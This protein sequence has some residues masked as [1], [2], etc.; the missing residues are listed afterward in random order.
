MLIKCPVGKHGNFC[1]KMGHLILEP[2]RKKNNTIYSQHRDKKFKLYPSSRKRGSYYRVHHYVSDE[3]GKRKSKWCYLGNFD[4]ALE[5][6][7]KIEKSL[8]KYASSKK[9]SGP[10]YDVNPFFIWKLSSLKDV[11][12]EIKRAKNLKKFKKN[13][14]TYAE[15]ISDTISASQNYEIIGDKVFSKDVQE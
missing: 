10:M 4:M 15:I 6:L 11:K 9:M 1:N 12:L 5:K 7:E 2:P 14:N 13:P 8:E 3:Y